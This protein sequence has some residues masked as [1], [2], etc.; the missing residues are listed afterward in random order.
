MPLT[1]SVHDDMVGKK[2]M[3]GALSSPGRLG[4]LQRPRFSIEWT[5]ICSYE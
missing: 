5:R 3:E 1:D 4:R 2:R